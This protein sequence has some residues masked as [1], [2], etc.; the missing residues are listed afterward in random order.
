MNQRTLIRNADVITM[1][2]ACGEIRG[3][4]IL[5][6]SG[7]IVRVAPDIASSHG[8]SCE[9][10][11]VVD[12]SGMIALPGL[13]DAHNCM[14]QTVLR[15]YVPDLWTGNYFTR[16]L[17]LRRYF[18]PV[19]NFNSGCV[20]GYEMLS[21]GTTTVVDYCHNIRAP[22]YADA[23]IEGLRESGIRHVFTYSFMSELPDAFDSEAA[24]FADARRVFERFDDPGS[25]TT[26]NFG[27]E[28]IGT[29][30]VA[31]QLAFAR[32]LG[33]ASCIHLNARGDVAAL[34]DQ[35]LLGPDL[36][37][38]HG[39]LLTDEE[40]RRMARSAMPLCFTPSAD[41]QGTPADVVR[42]AAEHG[43]P[44]VF[45][46]DVPCHVASDPLMQLRVMYA[47]QGFIDGLTA[48][49]RE[50]VTG[51]R[52]AVRPGMPLLRPADLIRRATI[53]CAQVLG[54][55]DRIGSLKAGKRADIVLVRKGLFGD[56]IA[57]DLCAH[58]LLQTSAREIDT[59]FVDGQALLSG[60]RLLNH[61][62]GRTA[63]RVSQS[64]AAIFAAARNG[65]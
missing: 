50:E 65:G 3:C 37:G 46:C 51:R 55:A 63:Q 25:R 35:G 26:V 20:G 64:R 60:G 38:I 1:E 33:A 58:L 16:L 57:D 48:R 11:A 10:A 59:V 19:D 52:P 32:A 13:I 31:G 9:G 36:L 34:D 56:S 15:G 28:S 47:V 21:Y 17:P 54:M 22:G 30:N 6:D 7:A 27:I 29:A 8:P 62:A 23:A 39:N 40:L 44:V 14:W 41:V 43:V 5:I 2:D 4:D 45:G 42:R 49:A 24:R 12:A 18:Q 53:G 61:D